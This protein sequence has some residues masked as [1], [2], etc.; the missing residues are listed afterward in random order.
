VTGNAFDTEPSVTGN[1]LDART[2]R[3][4]VAYRA[5]RRRGDRLRRVLAKKH[6]LDHITRGDYCCSLPVGNG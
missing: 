5:R 1:A 6:W 2:R 3:S 4:Q